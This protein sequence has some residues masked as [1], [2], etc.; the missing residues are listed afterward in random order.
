MQYTS[1]FSSYSTHLLKETHDF[2]HEILKLDTE[3]V[4]QRFIHVYL[5]NGQPLII[6]VKQDHRPS[7]YTVLNFQVTDIAETVRDLKTKGVSFLQ[8]DEPIKTDD[9]GI[10]WDD[11]GSHLAW[12]KDPG[13]NIIALI[14]N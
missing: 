7:N 14:E 10:S 9:Q 2:Y 3:I 11:N 13:G 5:P 1:V 8:Y 12:F 6:Y 4:R